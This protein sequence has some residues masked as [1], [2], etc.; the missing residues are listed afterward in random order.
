M[1]TKSYNVTINVLCDDGRVNSVSRTYPAESVA[2]IMHNA[3][4][5]VEDIAEYGALNLMS[6]HVHYDD[7]GIVNS[8][9]LFV[10]RLEFNPDTMNYELMP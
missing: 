7:N 1:K 2:S 10:K 9:L 6:M 3:R 4:C 8:E 5:D